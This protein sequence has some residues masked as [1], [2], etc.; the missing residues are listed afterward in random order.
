VE[1]GG[2]GVKGAGLGLFI[3]KSL[4]EA[5]GGHIS[6]V[7]TPGVGSTFWFTLPA[8]AEDTDAEV[9]PT[10]LTSVESRVWPNVSVS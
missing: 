8:L 6:V 1:A 3:C 9:K 7:S 2:T 5:Q 10:G 4:V